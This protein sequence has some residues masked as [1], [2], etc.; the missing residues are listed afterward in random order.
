MGRLA[1]PLRRRLARR[2][3]RKILGPDFEFFIAG[4]AKLPLDTAT[5][6]WALE[7]PVYEG[8][9]TTE[10]NCAIATNV[11]NHSRLGSVGQP[12]VGVESRIDPASGEILIRGPNVAAGYWNNEQETARSWTDGWY[13]THD[14]GSVDEDG[15][16]YIADRLD[17]IL[18]LQNGENVSATELE[19]RFAEIPYVDSAVVLGHQRPDLIALVTLNEDAVQRWAER[20]GLALAPK[21]QNDPAVLALLRQEMEQKVNAR[22]QRCFDRIRQI[23]II[24]PLGTLEQTLTP[25]EKVNRR[26]IQKR[27]AGLIESLYAESRASRSEPISPPTRQNSPPVRQTTL[28]VEVEP[29]SR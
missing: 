7:I 19:V 22:A 2:I 9:G 28:L 5:F 29:E 24:E 6:L 27:H 16:L 4:G 15:F 26:E 18:V 14:I 1:D 10:T 21:L 3:R 20:T 17:N 23:A 12:F 13:H 8:Y 25:T 11:P